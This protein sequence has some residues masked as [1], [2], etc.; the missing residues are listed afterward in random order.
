MSAIRDLYDA[1]KAA[2]PAVQYV[3][4]PSWFLRATWYAVPVDGHAFSDAEKAE[5]GR[6]FRAFSITAL[7]HEI[8]NGHRIN[9]MPLDDEPDDDGRIARLEEQVAELFARIER[10]R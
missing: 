8:R 3:T 1:V 10:K 9:R 6:V 7:E 5:I 2:V 4:V